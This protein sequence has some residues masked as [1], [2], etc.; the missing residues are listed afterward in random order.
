M[1]SPLKLR[2]YQILGVRQHAH[3]I[4][5]KN[6][7]NRLRVNYS[8]RASKVKYIFYR[9]AAWD[10]KPTRAHKAHRRFKSYCLPFHHARIDAHNSQLR[11]VLFKCVR[12]GLGGQRQIRL[13]KKDGS[14]LSQA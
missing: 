1:D 11:A 9:C 6:R 10:S 14:V 12:S 8:S 3:I 7:F 4:L 2:R 13:M 5:E